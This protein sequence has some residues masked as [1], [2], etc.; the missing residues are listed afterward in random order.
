MRRPRDQLAGRHDGNRVGGAIGEVGGA[1]DGIQR[2]IEV[3]RA[4]LPRAQL[5]SQGNAPGALSLMP[6]PMTTSPQMSTRS[7]TP[8]MASQAAASAVL[9][10]APQPVKVLKRGI[11][12]SPHELELEASLG[13]V[14]VRDSAIDLV[15]FKLTPHRG[16]GSAAGQRLF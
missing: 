15:W 16:I 10:T 1:V 8:S 9:A 4:N 11:L 12:G 6:S 14:A 2:D 5:I 13:S 7:N 3:R